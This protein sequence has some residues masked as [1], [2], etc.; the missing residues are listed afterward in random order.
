MEK[1]E[2]A[3]DNIEDTEEFP[4]LSME[5][6]IAKAIEKFEKTESKQSAVT[7]SASASPSTAQPAAS[8]EP[9]AAVAVKEPVVAAAA[10]AVSAAVPVAVGN[11]A[12]VATPVAVQE[13]QP[14]SLRKGNLNFRSI[15]ITRSCFYLFPL[16]VDWLS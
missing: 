1:D 12:P 2:G 7:T 15:H 5:D 16:Q 11:V 14:S 10:A 6:A 9:A 3:V 13:A 4:V 8:K